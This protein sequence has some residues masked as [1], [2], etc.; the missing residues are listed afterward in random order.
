[1]SASNWAICPRCLQRAKE[2]ATEQLAKI[3]SVLGAEE[4]EALQDRLQVN[5]EDFRTFREDYEF[6]GN[7]ENPRSPAPATG[8][9]KI[10]A[11]YSGSCEECG[12]GVDF[13]HTEPIKGV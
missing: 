10:T 13:E 11:S 9:Y 5:E 3:A 4:A 12:L 1:M 8:A 7:W 2:K 6:Y